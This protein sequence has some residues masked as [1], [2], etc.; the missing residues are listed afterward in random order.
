MYFLSADN[1]RARP[2][3]GPQSAVNSG[4]RVESF[5]KGTAKIIFKQSWPK[6]FHVSP[7]NSRKGSYTLKTSDPLSPCIQ[8]T[9]PIF[10]TITLLSSKGHCKLVATLS[11]IGPAIDPY[12]LSA[13]GKLRF[14]VSWCWIGFLTFP[15]ILAQAFTLYSRHKLHVW[16]RPE[17]L[18]TSLSRRATPTERQ[19]EPIFRR[20]LQHLVS[21][22]C[23]AF[24][25]KYTPAGIPQPT[26]PYLLRSRAALRGPIGSGGE[27]AEE[28]E[29]KVLTPGFYARFVRYA[30]SFE[31][32]S[33]EL[34]ESGTIWVSRPEL[35]ARIA[36]A[37]WVGE[38]EGRRS[39]S[40]GEYLALGAIQH[41]RARSE[42]VVRPFPTS[43]MNNG[44]EAG[45]GPLREGSG[46]KGEGGATTG[47]EMQGMDAYV[48][49]REDETS[50]ERYLSCVLRVVLA[51]KIAFGSVALL[52]VEWGLVR[53][54]LAWLV[55][56][57]LGRMLERVSI[58]G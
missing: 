22:S 24:A 34:N 15:R 8:G 13:S 50:R 46:I 58:S 54:G 25:V 33:R 26:N 18:P 29:V 4:E 7:F 43:A 31:A 37:R 28:L 41:L 17:P 36:A 51:E 10:N 16:Y 45:S 30:D 21:R 35:L 52:E 42:R 32:F 55:S 49:E 12:T 11:S 38:A 44:P 39:G 19:L 1:E 6:D 40:V 14:L 57:F 5:R 2:T 23:T 56:V 20:Y 53:V 48:L 3:D 27:R 47:L 9:G